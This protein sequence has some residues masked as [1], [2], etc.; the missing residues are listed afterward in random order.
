MQIN[1]DVL[2]QN[3]HSLAQVG[4]AANDHVELIDSPRTSRAVSAHGFIKAPEILALLCQL[5]ADTVMDNLTGAGN[6]DI[7]SSVLV[8]NVN[9]ERYERRVAPRLQRGELRSDLML[10]MRGVSRVELVNI[11]ETGVLVE[12]STRAVIGSVADLFIT[13]DQHCHAV[14]AKTVRSKVIAIQS[15]AVMYRVAFQFEERLSLRS[16]LRK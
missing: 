10:T 4:V 13:T 6:P 1:V 11:S 9:R 8:P 7:P 2:N 12:M 5:D 16:L 3:E 14:R 15:G